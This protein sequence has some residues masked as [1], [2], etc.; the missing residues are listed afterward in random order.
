MSCGWQ[1]G[2]YIFN[3]Q[4]KKV[5]AIIIIIPSKGL[6]AIL[7]CRKHP[8]IIFISGH[9]KIHINQRKQQN[10]RQNCWSYKV[11][12]VFD[13]FNSLSSVCIFLILFLLSVVGLREKKCY[14][15][16]SKNYYFS[17]RLL[18]KIIYYTNEV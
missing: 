11:N 2:W 8:W 7:F 6:H 12:G 1:R 14:F 17:M 18:L 16:K 15:W 9:W 13:M 5:A 4:G 10:S 3:T